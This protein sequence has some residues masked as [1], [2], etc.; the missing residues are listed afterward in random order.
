MKRRV[1]CCLQLFFYSFQYILL[2][3]RVYFSLL[4]I[5]LSLFNLVIMGILLKLIHQFWQFL[6]AIRWKFE[7]N[8]KTDDFKKFIEK[9]NEEVYKELK[10]EVI[11][12]R[13][14]LWLEFLLRKEE[15]MFEELINERRDRIRNNP[16]MY[17]HE[18]EEMRRII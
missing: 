5:Q 11:P 10:I 9:Q 7:F 6:D 13:K 8:Y 15:Q 3:I 1:N 2:L 16:E 18:K 4:V 17:Q 12:E 14:G